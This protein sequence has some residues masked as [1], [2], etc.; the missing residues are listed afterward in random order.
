MIRSGDGDLGR[1]CSEEK[2][3]ELHCAF[4]KVLGS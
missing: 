3:V 2:E 4:R 1:N